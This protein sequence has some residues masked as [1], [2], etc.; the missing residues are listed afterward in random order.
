MTTDLLPMDREE[1]VSRRAKIL[2]HC[3]SKLLTRR[4]PRFEGAF[5]M[6]SMFKELVLSFWL[7]CYVFL[8]ILIK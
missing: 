8:S 1:S 4:M 6:H 3:V 5:T 7:R 2:C